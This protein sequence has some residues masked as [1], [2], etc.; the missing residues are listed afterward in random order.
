VLS[1][2]GN[3]RSSYTNGLTDL[4]SSGQYSVS[5]GGVSNWKALTSDDSVFCSDMV[6]DL[7]EV[8]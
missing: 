8:V 4:L 5:D 3:D 2:N 1:D 6:I 7:G